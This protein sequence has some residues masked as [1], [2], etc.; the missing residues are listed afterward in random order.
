[1]SFDST[2][3][4]NDDYYDILGPD[5]DLLE[6]IDWDRYEKME[7][8]CEAWFNM[9]MNSS[10]CTVA[11]PWM[12]TNFDISRLDDYSLDQVTEWFNCSLEIPV[13]SFQ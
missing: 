10:G 1:M 9:T 13:Y 4:N 11:P 12:W 3:M 2:N 7:I 6:R 5:A 8:L